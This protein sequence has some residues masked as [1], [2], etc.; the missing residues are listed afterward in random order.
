LSRFAFLLRLPVIVG[1]AH[2]YVA[3]RLATALED[4]TG[5]W[6]VATGILLLYLLIMTGFK[7]RRAAG[8][9]AGDLAAWAGFL[10]LGYFA[11]LFVLTLCR[12]MLLG[13]VAAGKAAGVLPPQI[14]TGIFMPVNPQAGSLSG[15]L[16]AAASLLYADL[17]ACSA[18]LVI[19]L[20][21]LAVLL[22]LYNSRRVARVVRVDIP[23]PGLPQALEGLTIAQLTDIHVGPTI[24]RGY[25]RGIVSRTNALRPDIIA[26]TGDLI[27][28]SVERLRE[29]VAPLGQL[30]ARH[31][32][33]AVTGNHEYYSGADAWVAEFRRIG[34]DV[35]MNEHRLVERD[36]ATLVLAG[37]TDFGA[38]AFDQRQASDPEA[39]LRGS[40]RNAGARI[41]LAHQPR[42]APAAAQAGFD[43]QLSGH[44]HGG[45]F[46]PWRYFV[47]L[48][49]PFVSGLHYQDSMA[50]YVSQGTGYWGPPMRIGA[51]SEI[52]L[53]RLTQA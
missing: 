2:F 9:P 30:Q 51:K 33:Y 27:D 23:L 36:G 8:R 10:A 28:G 19:L 14:H 40:P 6:A 31:G 47:P 50:V 38:G 4:A 26:I 53:I 20:A 39:A 48:Q 29:D 34:L 46:W 37:V 11:W 45:Q 17:A 5:R 35:L 15:Q 7:T 12:D 42:S 52:T 32:V 18:L 3:L 41:L 44:T 16:H 24:K 1:L 25:V 43:L 22:G 21:L 13:I 49:Q